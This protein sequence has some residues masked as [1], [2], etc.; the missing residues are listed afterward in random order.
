MST[1]GIAEAAMTDDATRRLMEQIGWAREKG[2]PALDEPSAK[3]ILAACGIGVPMSCVVESGDD[4]TRTTAHLRPPLALKVVSPDVLH[5]S[6]VGG[7][8]LGLRSHDELDGAIATMRETLAAKGVHADRWLVE[9]MAAPG[10]EVVVGAVVDAEFG[11]MLMVGLGGIFIE[12]LKDVAF[13]ICPIDAEDAREMLGE[14]RGAA[15]LQGARGR[16]GVAIDAIIGVLLRLGG[17]DGLFSRWN[18]EI[19]EI[20]INPLIVTAAGAVAA[21]ARFVLASRRKAEPARQPKER[22]DFAPLFS[23]NTIA[24][25][26]ASASATSGGNRFI[27]FLT[28]FGY[29]GTILPIHPTAATIEGIPAY[30][31]LA[32]LPTA[33]DY[34]YVA[35]AAKSVA[36][37]LQSGRG[38]VRFAQVMSS[39]FSETNEGHALEEQLLDAARQSH[40]RVIGPNCM[41]LY[42]PRARVSFTERATAEAGSVAVICQSGGL[43][44][45]IIR[46]GQNKGLRFSAVITVGNCA[47]VAPSE[48]VE[49]F[50]A[51]PDTS[52]IGLYLEGTREGRRL[53]ETLRAAGARKPMVLMKGGRTPQGQ[54]AAVSHTGALAGSDRAWESLAHQTG[55]AMAE[56]LDDFLDALVAFQ[57][58]TPRKT[59]TRNVVLFGNGG[60]TSV[61]GADAF[62]RQGFAVPPLDATSVASLLALRLPAGSSVANPIDV[63][64]GALRQGAGSAAER[65]IEAVFSSAGID[66]LVIH[67]NMTV[68]LDYKDVDLLGNIVDAALRVRDRAASSIHLALVLRSDGEADIE[69]RK[70]D[71]RQRAVAQAVPVFDELAQA[72]RALACLRRVE[73]FRARKAR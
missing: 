56:G 53:F 38:L 59:P 7:V 10:V 54:R 37:V 23:P 57:C 39:G 41:G 20:D 47:D 58:L 27:R 46:R 73:S 45:D 29:P 15:L 8:S 66:A 1:P 28:Q 12:V 44:I 68:V 52:T 32:A 50:L 14:L 24:V 2:W 61:L 9:E 5:K 25:V 51:D 49:H 35:V 48:L 17:E 21:D 4:L 30:P 43:G 36:D 40:I 67:V 63:P 26:G 13:R 19:A 42:A 16:A 18:A 69:E 62:D 60:G 11:P 22:A 70:R 65:I 71:Y 3:S 64:A 34:A 55:T 33:V 72:A 6:D 31:S